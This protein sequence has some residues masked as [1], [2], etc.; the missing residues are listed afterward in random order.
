MCKELV[1]NK[2]LSAL[3][4]VRQAFLCIKHL[5]Q[6]GFPQLLGDVMTPSGG[7]TWSCTFHPTSSPSLCQLRALGPI[8]EAPGAVAGALLQW[9][10]H[11]KFNMKP[12][13]SGKNNCHFHLSLALPLLHLPE[14][15]VSSK[16]FMKLQ[17]RLSMIHKCAELGCVWPVQLLGTKSVGA[18]SVKAGPS[19]P[20]SHGKQGQQQKL[21]RIKVLDKAMSVLVLQPLWVSCPLL[22]LQ[23]EVHKSLMRL[24]GVSPLSWK[25]RTIILP[26]ILN[27]LI[28]CKTELCDCKTFVSSQ[29]SYFI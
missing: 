14:H 11:V 19:P 28:L 17:E 26:L 1:Q 2:G 4:C 8:G 7:E 23:P 29:S 24:I 15:R 25:W 5:G 12:W 22:F 21:Y 3:P 6:K 9:W 10:E 16:G 27:H 13:R 20:I 18:V